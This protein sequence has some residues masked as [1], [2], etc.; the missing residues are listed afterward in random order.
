MAAVGWVGAKVADAVF[1]RGAHGLYDFAEDPPCMRR[2]THDDSNRDHDL[3]GEYALLSE[4]FYYFGDHPIALP[5]HLQELVK[6]GPGHRDT[7]N[8]PYIELF[9][10]WLMASSNR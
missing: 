9:A 7:Q 10:D 8:S 4:H 2:S 5:E 1:I 3:S 6:R